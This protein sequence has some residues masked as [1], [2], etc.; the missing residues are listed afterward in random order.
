LVV[1][2]GNSGCD[3]AVEAAQHATSAAI[4]MRRGYHFFPK[5]LRGLPIDV[6]GERLHRWGLPAWL[7]RKIAA[8]MVYFTVG[9]LKHYGLPEPEHRLFETH[10]IVNSQL[11]YELGHGH[12]R[13]KPNIAELRG[14]EILFTDGTQEAFDLIVF[15]TGYKL[16]FPFLDSQWILNEQG[17]LRLFLNAFHP[18]RDDFLVA[19]LIQPDS[20]IW[21]LADLQCQLF[22]K[23]QQALA[24]NAPSA[25]RFQKMKTQGHDDLG[26]G[27]RYLNTP[28][29]R[30]EVEYHSYRARLRKLLTLF[31]N[32][33]T[34]TV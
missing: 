34:H 12:I 4:S 6:R 1:G 25:T 22:A 16:S 31:G 8:W 29:H 30:L 20:G 32:L 24:A 21:G 11:L 28:R 27:L 23:Y 33:P 9:P 18:E 15:A 3:I 13:V 17:E 14:R 19:G 5:F 2:A 10:P 7:R 26:N